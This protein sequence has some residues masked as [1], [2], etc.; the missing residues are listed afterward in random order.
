MVKKDS[1]WI[2]CRLHCSDNENFANK[3]EKN[4]IIKILQNS[5]IPLSSLI[6]EE[7]EKRGSIL[8][9]EIFKSIIFSRFQIIFTNLNLRIFI[10]RTSNRYKNEIAL[11]SQFVTMCD[12]YFSVQLLYIGVTLNRCKNYIKELF[13]RLK[14][15]EFIPSIL[16]ELE[17]PTHCG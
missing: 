9:G 12:N 11:L 2:L 15:E 3:N 16:K 6:K 8:F 7:Y 10:I 4:N 5:N 17:N 14:I 13:V 1:V